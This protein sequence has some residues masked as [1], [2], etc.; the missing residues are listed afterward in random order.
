LTHW[1]LLEK[2]FFYDKSFFEILDG[3][4]LRMIAS[5][6]LK[7]TPIANQFNH[8]L[9]RLKF[10]HNDRKFSITGKI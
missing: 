1:I 2:L 7:T 10:T 6:K 4:M 5:H 8:K 9:D 3:L